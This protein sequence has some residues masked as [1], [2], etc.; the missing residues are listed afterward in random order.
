[1]FKPKHL[2]NFDPLKPHFYIVKLGFTGVYT[3]FLISAQQ[4]DCGYSIEPLFRGGSNEY[5]QSIFEQKYEEYKNF[6][7]SG[8]FHFLVVKFSVNLYRHIF[9][10]HVFVLRC[11][12]V[13]LLPSMAT[14]F[15]C[16]F[17]VCAFIICFILEAGAKVMFSRR[18]LCCIFFFFC[19]LIGFAN[20]VIPYRK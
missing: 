15:V 3:V 11:L 10:M 9:V 4:I 20:V 2:Y 7:L 8:S 13:W 5:P 6:F 16:C 1:M 14:H 18:F 19:S 17:S 12:A